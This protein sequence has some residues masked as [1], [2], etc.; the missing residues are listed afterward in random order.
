MKIG[1]QIKESRVKSGFTQEDVAEK[2]QV[3]RQTISNWENEKFYP[4]IISLIKMSDLY[5]ISL[6]ELLKGDAQMIQHL[7]E[8]TNTVNSNKKLIL[9]VI[10]NGILL[11]LFLFFNGLIANNQYLMIGSV[12]IGILST[13]F[14]FYQFIKQI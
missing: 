2:L 9:A 14:L 7:E 3:S 8:S 13:M 10:L 4:D 12:A 5:T 6:D 11:I 1:Q